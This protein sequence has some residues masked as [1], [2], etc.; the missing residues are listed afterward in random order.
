MTATADTA[1]YG[2]RHAASGR[3]GFLL[4]HG[5]PEDHPDVRAAR[6]E[7]AFFRVKAVFDSDPGLDRD[8]LLTRV[9]DALTDD[10]AVAR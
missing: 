9:R 5:Y 4:K 3:L 2:S 6:S 1:R 10:A 7:I 8:A